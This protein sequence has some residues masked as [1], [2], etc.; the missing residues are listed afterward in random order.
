MKKATI[1]SI[2]ALFIFAAN[3]VCTQSQYWA[4]AK[5]NDKNTTF[6]E[7]TA[8]VN[9]LLIAG[10]LK[11][12]LI[13]DTIPGIRLI[14]DI[15]AGH[16]IILKQNLKKSRLKIAANPLIPTNEK[17]L[18]LVS[19]PYLKSITIKDEATVRTLT[20]LCVDNLQIIMDADGKVDVAVAGGSVKTRMRGL[21]TIRITGPIQQV[22][23]QTT[24]DGWQISF[25]KPLAAGSPMNKTAGTVNN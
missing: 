15:S 14:G 7:I 22:S 21:G 3:T 10:E 11:I 20:P 17:P 8:P 2:L 6:I 16:T 23:S 25:F 13:S 1:Y 5:I 19:L 12:V 9:E 18:V 24:I 4:C